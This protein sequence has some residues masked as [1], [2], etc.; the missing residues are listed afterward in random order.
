MTKELERLEKLFT[1]CDEWINDNPCE[2]GDENPYIE[3][4]YNAF[5]KYYAKHYNAVV[6]YKL[7]SGVEERFVVDEDAL[8]DATAHSCFDCISLEECFGLLEYWVGHLYEEYYWRDIDGDVSV[9]TF[10]KDGK[11]FEV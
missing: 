11:K 8:Y 3:K 6:S 5:L 1:K 2:P 7:K 9:E 10:T 4:I